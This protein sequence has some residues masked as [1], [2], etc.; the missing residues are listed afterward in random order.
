MCHIC[1][2]STLL[3]TDASAP[4]LSIHYNDTLIDLKFRTHKFVPCQTKTVNSQMKI[5]SSHLLDNLKNSGGS[6]GLESMTSAMLVQC[7]NQLSY[8]VTK[9]K[10][11]HDL[12]VLCFPVKGMSYERNV[13][14]VRVY[15]LKQLFF[16]MS[17]NSGFRNI[18][19]A[20]W[21]LG[22]YQATI[23]LDLKE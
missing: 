12:L 9:L 18:Y 15:I 20:T 3:V 16:S 19:L 13:I 6:T 10:A 2:L 7:S 21:W 5:W 22:K 4:R 8:E 1:P 14:L 23:H 17:V 11:G